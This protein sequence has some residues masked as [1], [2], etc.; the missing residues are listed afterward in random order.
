MTA[1]K[2]VGTVCAARGDVPDTLRAKAV[3]Q[4]QV[5]HY[6]GQQTVATADCCNRQ[7]SI[8]SLR[9]VKQHSARIAVMR[10]PQ[11]A[12][13]VMFEGLTAYF[14]QGQTASQLGLS[15][16]KEPSRLQLRSAVCMYNIRQNTTELCL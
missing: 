13:Q 11:E 10:Q 6:A 2:L 5:I 3:V 12:D 1:C 16:H 4:E 8:D 14:L 15:C 7:T 9:A